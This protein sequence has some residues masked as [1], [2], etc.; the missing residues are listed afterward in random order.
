MYEALEQAL[1]RMIPWYDEL[2]CCE[3]ALYLYDWE[4]GRRVGVA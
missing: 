1:D 2:R 3:R 4:P